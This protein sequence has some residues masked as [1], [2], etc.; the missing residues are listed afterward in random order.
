M[1]IIQILEQDYQKFPLDQNYNIYA[2]NVYFQDPLNKFRGI[3]QYQKMIKNLTK[4]FDNIK[5]EIHQIEQ[6]ES[7]IKTEWTLLMNFS[8][9]PWKPRLKISGYSELILNENHLII[10]HQDY[11]YIS[12][13]DVLKQVFFLGN[14]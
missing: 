14:N 10:S 4:F 7:L 3:D 9:L 11:W 2:K 5:M 13:F 6:K 1:N 12:R 8:L